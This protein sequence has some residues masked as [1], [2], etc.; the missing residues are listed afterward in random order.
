M[1][2]ILAFMLGLNRRD[3]TFNLAACLK[4][5]PRVVFLIDCA[6]L[7]TPLLIWG[8]RRTREMTPASGSRSAPG[9]EEMQRLMFQARKV[10]NG[11]VG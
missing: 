1:P 2:M 4:G 3:L 10:I 11:L 5:V 8:A 7:A 6:N 9:I